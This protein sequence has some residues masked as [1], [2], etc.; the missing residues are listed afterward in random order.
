MSKADEQQD[1]DSTSPTGTDTGRRPRH[2]AVMVTCCL[3]MF[4]AFIE[5]T[6]AISTLRSMQVELSV[7]PAF[8]SWVSS[9]YTLALAALVLSGGAI[10]ER[11]GRKRS[12]LSGVVILAAGSLVVATAPTF[13]VVMAGRV[14]SGV[15]GALILPLSLAYVVM[16]FTDANQRARMIS[17]W[18]SMSGVALALGPV[19]GGALNSM[20]SWRAVFVINTP[21]ALVTVP[22]GVYALRE[23]A[24]PQRRLDPGGQFLAVVG[25]TGLVYGVIA[26]GRDGYAATHVLASLGLGVLCLIG[27]VLVE[28]RAEQPMLDVRMMRSLPYSISLFLA[29]VGLFGFVGVT[30]VQV[31]F[32]QQVQRHT[33]LE[34]GLRLLAE[35]V[36]FMVVTVLAGRW[37]ARFG[38]ARMLLTGLFTA[39]VAALL[40]STQDADTSYLFS[41][42]ALA[43]VGAGSGLVIAPSTSAALS[44]VPPQRAPAASNAVTG[45]RQVGSVLGT[46]VLGAVLGTRFAGALADE[47]AEANVAAP[48]AEALVRAARQG[49]P[50]S[51]DPVVRA[52]ILRSYESGVQLSLLCNSVLLLCASGVAV[53][54][55]VLSRRKHS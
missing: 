42:L 19:L 52:A 39:A 36:A 47:L 26:G 31:M 41:G 2:L 23:A 13:G 24:N 32:L 8:L 18:V 48:R 43:L 11:F 20:T 16:T 49:I 54:F 51:E 1:S 37:T 40:L 34:S 25:L 9:A 44:V 45:F 29:A 17:V 21:L 22:L 55:V 28:A 7:P 15:G 35:M 3:G 6:A 10:G 50:H 27:L 12:Y 53:V 33:P 4:M 30:Y 14:I 46:A 5:V 38:P